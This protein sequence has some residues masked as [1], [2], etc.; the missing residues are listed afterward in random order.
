M[1]VGAQSRYHVY[2]SEAAPE[3]VINELQTRHVK[4][5]QMVGGRLQKAELGM[6]DQFLASCAS[7]PELLPCTWSQTQLV[8]KEFFFFHQISVICFALL[9]FVI[10]K[11]L[12]LFRTF[13]FRRFVGFGLRR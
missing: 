13:N 1:D 6:W 2:P 5:Q 8:K 3:E 10:M 7:E 9:F 12:S 11:L 4:L